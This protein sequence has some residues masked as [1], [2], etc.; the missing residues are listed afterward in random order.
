MAGCS[1]LPP[2]LLTSLA[3]L[4]PKIGAPPFSPGRSIATKLARTLLTGLLLFE[5]SEWA[6]DRP[7][8]GGD[9]D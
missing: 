6:G 9:V 4:R 5:T 8:L 2:T 1:P 7:R 3:L